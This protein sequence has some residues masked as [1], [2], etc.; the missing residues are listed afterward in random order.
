M[1]L[2]F[3][4]KKLVIYGHSKGGC[5]IAL[6]LIKY[7]ELQE[8]MYGVITMQAPYNGSYMI[9]WVVNNPVDKAAT[10][11]VETLFAGEKAAYEDLAY[12]SRK[13]IR[14]Q[15]EFDGR[16]IP[17]VNMCTYGG[18]ELKKENLD[19]INELAGL[20]S[21]RFCHDVI[22]KAVGTKNDG[23]VAPADGRMPGAS[24]VYLENM[25]HTEPAMQM[26]GTEY[27]NGALSQALL[28]CLLEKISREGTNTT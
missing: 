16:K 6:A 19:T 8:H 7:P 18:F 15:Y 28:A 9:D 14:E 26:P 21:M 20:G 27:K 22:M 2:R 12:P 23:M 25:Y 1:H 5:D 13:A 17:T 24:L 3:P 10:K 11:V 4:S